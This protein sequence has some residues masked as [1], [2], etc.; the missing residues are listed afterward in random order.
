[1]SIQLKSFLK[2]IKNPIFLTVVIFTFCTIYAYLFALN[3]S[4]LFSGNPGAEL[5]LE[6]SHWTACAVSGPGVGTCDFSEVTVPSD[7]PNA[8]MKDF[9]GWILYKVNFTA[10]EKCLTDLSSCAFFFEEI[11]DAAEAKVNGHIIGRHGQ[12]PPNA[13]YAKHYPVELQLSRDILKTGEDANELQVLVYS[14]KRVQVGI[15]QKPVGIYT[16]ENAEKLSRRY[17]ILNVIY[18]LLSF[19]GLFMMALFSLAVLGTG[20][21][22]EPKFTAYVRYVLITSSF[23]ISISEVP[24]EYLPI[25]LAGYLHFILRISSDW[26]FFEMIGK[27]FDFQ[28]RNLRKIRYLYK[29]SILAFIIEFLFYFHAS[30]GSSG[31]ASNGFATGFTTL[32]IIVPII[33]LPHCMGLYASYKRKNTKEGQFLFWFFLG[34]LACQIHDSSVFQQVAGGV[35]YI[36]WYAFFIGLV[37]GALFLDKFRVAKT[38]IILERE[39]IK[40]MEMIHEAT[41]GVAHDLEEPLKGLEMAC[42][43]LKRNPDNKSLIHAIADTFPTK[44]QRIYELNKAILSYSKELSKTIEVNKTEINLNEFLESVAA[45]FRPQILFASVDLR[46]LVSNPKL[47][48]DADANQL[49]RVLRNLIRNAGEAVKGTLNAKVTIEASVNSFIAP[50]VKILVSDNGPGVAPEIKDKLFRPFESFGKE[51]G[52]GLGLAM[53]RRLIEMQGGNLELVESGSGAVFQLRL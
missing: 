25:W 20:L 36:K 21:G 39:Q 19:V 4:P 35:Y 44:V 14:S 47:T 42:N 26:A 51:N 28:E 32:R 23:L 9:K 48:V 15:R 49:R 40:Q 24:R 43:E 45:E 31:D 10:P 50:R 7:L 29:L 8:I 2:E 1:M 53:S 12:F 37:F 3:N 30:Y 11:G 5:N 41:V 22:K 52:T 16:L 13:V 18:P 46:V 33:I 27:Y 17:T 34:T 6:K 38:K